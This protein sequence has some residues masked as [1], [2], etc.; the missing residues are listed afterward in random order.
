MQPLKFKPILKETIWGGKKIG[1]F[2]HID[3]CGNNIGESLEIS[4]VK[5]RE[6]I[7]ANGP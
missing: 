1:T 6:S 5:H 7:V 3:A 4:G 2:K